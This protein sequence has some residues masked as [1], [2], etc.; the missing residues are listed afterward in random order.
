MVLNK[1]CLFS[2]ACYQQF[3]PS[4]DLPVAD[5]SLQIKKANIVCHNCGEPGHKSIYCSKLTKTQGTG[6]DIS[7]HPEKVT[8][9]SQ[10]SSL[11]EAL[12]F[13]VS[14]SALEISHRDHFSV[15]YA[16]CFT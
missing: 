3:S 10:L 9:S 15:S 7:A 4:Y 5:P 1:F 16:V 6:T 2:F 8:S 11:M 14:N 13:C 12:F